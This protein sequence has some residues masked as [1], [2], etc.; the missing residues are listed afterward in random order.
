MTETYVYMFTLL[1]NVRFDVH[2]LRER[3]L[4]IEGPGGFSGGSPVLYRDLEGVMYFAHVLG[5]GSHILYRKKSDQILSMHYAMH[6]K[7]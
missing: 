2:D 4:F 7:S 3:S 1:L 6:Q 5:G